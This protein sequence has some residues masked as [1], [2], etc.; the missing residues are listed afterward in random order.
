MPAEKR[1]LPPRGPAPKRY[2]AKPLRLLQ[3]RKPNAASK[4]ILERNSNQ[5]P[6][7]RLPAEVRNQIYE[8]ALSRE[9]VHVDVQGK[10]SSREVCHWLCS[11]VISEQ[12]A[13]DQSQVPLEIHHD[14]QIPLYSTR[15]ER[16]VKP[17]SRRG[18]LGRRQKVLHMELL[19]SCK[20]VYQETALL[21][22]TH[23]TFSFSS[24]DALTC[25]IS[26]LIPDQRCALRAFHFRIPIDDMPQ[27]T[28]PWNDA[29]TVT[30]VKSLPGLR[31]LRLDLALGQHCQRLTNL[32]RIPAVQDVGYVLPGV[33]CLQ[34]LELEDVTVIVNDI[35]QC[36]IPEACRYM[37]WNANRWSHADRQQWVAN[38]RQKL[39]SQWDETTWKKKIVE[40]EKKAKAAGI[41]WRLMKYMRKDD[42]A[43]IRERMKF[44]YGI[45]VSILGNQ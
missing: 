5:S 18:S 21:P 17:T 11:A 20:Q 22:Y 1:Q 16:C 37:K 24:P 4:A 41:S 15:H 43:G 12:E 30:L 29:I 40:H 14:D 7:L 32:A 23:N 2:K 39:L 28:W 27:G 8:Y 3:L 31:V 35:P 19:R 9:L 38:L 36:K 26:T 25:F 10:E 6:L 42:H 33:L 45:H 44:F 34:R 13:Y